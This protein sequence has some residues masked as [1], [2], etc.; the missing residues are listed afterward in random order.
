MLCI[1]Q[2]RGL[3]GG[4]SLVALS[5]SLHATLP[6]TV[7]AALQ[8]ALSATGVAD[9]A[10]G[11]QLTDITSIIDDLEAKVCFACERRAV[12][13]SVPPSCARPAAA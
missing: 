12:T 8:A 5:L 9:E 13:S 7:T 2:W 6:Q 10:V 11:S 4:R 3:C 1:L